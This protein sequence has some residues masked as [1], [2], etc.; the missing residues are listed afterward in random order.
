MGTTPELAKLISGKPYRLNE[1]D[2]HVKTFSL[3]LGLQSV[4]GDYNRYRKA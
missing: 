4:L 2:L 1:N 3:N